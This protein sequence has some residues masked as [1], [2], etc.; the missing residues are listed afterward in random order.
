MGKEVANLYLRDK[1]QTKKL[2]QS[3]SDSIRKDAYRKTLNNSLLVIHFVQSG[4]CQM[5]H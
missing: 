3:I 1:N 2:D 4:H 5:N